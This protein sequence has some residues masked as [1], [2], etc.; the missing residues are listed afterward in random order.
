MSQEHI[1][2][3]ITLQQLG[4]SSRLKLMTGVKDIHHMD[5]GNTLRLGR[6]PNARGKLG[7]VSHMWITLDPDD[8]YTVRTSYTHG[9]TNTEREK[10][11]GIY[12]DRLHQT[13][14]D[15]TGLYLT[16]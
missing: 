10:V 1:P 3:N 8:T 11:D 6:I 15:L 12:C 16:F 13:F 4:G 7:R 14:T 9:M 5:G 2:A